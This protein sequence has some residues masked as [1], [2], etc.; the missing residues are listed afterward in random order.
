MI[1][2]DKNAEQEALAHV[3]EEIERKIEDELAGREDLINDDD[4]KETL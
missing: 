3:T 4:R 1:A 2:G